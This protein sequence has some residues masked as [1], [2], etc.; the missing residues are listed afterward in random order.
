MNA[1]DIDSICNTIWEWIDSLGLEGVSSQDIY[2]EDPNARRPDPPSVSYRFLT[3][4]IK[5]GARDNRRYDVAN[6][7]W[8]TVGH[9]DI[10]V[11]MKTYGKVAYQN[12]VNIQASVE[13]QSVQDILQAGNIAVRSATTI[14]EVSQELESGIEE[15]FSLDVIIGVSSC[16]E[17]DLGAIEEVVITDAKVRD[18]EGTEV[19]TINETITKP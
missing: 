19:E 8:Q 4:P 18:P 17:E 15:R 6:D 10:T 13:L 9:R 7:I 14:Q 3:G 1:I 12:A 5:Q 16:Q 11:S 2:L